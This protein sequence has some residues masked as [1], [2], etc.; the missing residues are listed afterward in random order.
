MNA[1]LFAAILAMDSYNRGYGAG[2]EGLGGAGTGIGNATIG[3]DSTLRLAEGADVAAGFYAVS[4]TDQTTGKVYISYRGTDNPNPLQKGNDLWN[5]WT[6]GIGYSGASQAGLA[7]DFY[8]QI[9]GQSVY[10]PNASNVLLTGHSLGG[11]LAGFVSA[12]SGAQAIGFDHI[13]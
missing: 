6:A 12:L 4:Y 3:D 1:D 7:I 8:Q 5:G 9:T 2:I 11:G 13:K 10:D